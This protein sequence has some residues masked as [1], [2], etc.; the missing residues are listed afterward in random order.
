VLLALAPY[1]LA[2]RVVDQR[3]N[4]L[5]ASS[6]KLER[7]EMLALEEIVQARGREAQLNLD[8]ASGSRRSDE[9][10]LTPRVRDDWSVATKDD[11]QTWVL[12]SLRVRGGSASLVDVCRDVWQTHEPELRLSGDLFYTWQYDI[13]WAAQK[14]RDSGALKPDNEA[15]RGVWQLR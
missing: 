4:E 6:L 12:D 10:P 1:Q 5:A 15:P 11:L 14:L 7:D 13:R 3:P 9:L 2:L 8:G